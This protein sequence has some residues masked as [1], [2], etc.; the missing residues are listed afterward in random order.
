MGE[1]DCLGETG[2]ATAEKKHSV[3]ATG[4]LKVIETRPLEC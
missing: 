1:L 3:R 2:G 4:R